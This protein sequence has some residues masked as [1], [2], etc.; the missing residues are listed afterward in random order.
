MERVNV[1]ITKNE[2]EAL[3]MNPHLYEL[4][5]LQQGVRMFRDVTP[6]D[7]SGFSDET[8]MRMIRAVIGGSDPCESI[9]ERIEG[10]YKA[11]LR[12]L[13]TLGEPLREARAG[14]AH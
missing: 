12:A 1:K 7:L 10:D 3:A 11:I 6:A 13:N 14:N 2:A 9:V 8:V 4:M 5:A